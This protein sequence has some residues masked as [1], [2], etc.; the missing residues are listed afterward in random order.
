MRAW[1][2]DVT[3]ISGGSEFLGVLMF[4]VQATGC[5]PRPSGDWWPLEARIPGGPDVNGSCVHRAAQM[6]SHSPRDLYP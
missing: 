1:G 6:S 3:S 5:W 4:G 2:W